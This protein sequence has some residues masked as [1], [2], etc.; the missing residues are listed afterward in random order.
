MIKRGTCMDTI[1][2]EDSSLSV[3]VEW[4]YESSECGDGSLDEEFETTAFLKDGSGI[5]LTQEE[6]DFLLE[7][8]KAAGELYA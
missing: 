2:R 7:D 5:E 3:S 4:S 1:F 6:K 8:L